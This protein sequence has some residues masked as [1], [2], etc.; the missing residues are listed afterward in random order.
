M[1]TG[2]DHE[3]YDWLF[4]QVTDGVF[5]YE[6][7]HDRRWGYVLTNGRRVESN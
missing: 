5:S 2:K 3:R 7:E 6:S 1:P 4:Q